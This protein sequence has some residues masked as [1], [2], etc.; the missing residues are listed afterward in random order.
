[1]G[2]VS[3]RDSSYWIDPA[4]LP[5]FAAAGTDAHRVY[6]GGDAWIERFGA[7]LLLSYKGPRARDAALGELPA[8]ARGAPLAY[9]RVFGKFIPVKNE[10]R[11]APELIEGDASLPPTT[12]VRE[13]GMR[14]GIDFAA[15]YSAG[16]F[17]DQRANR[18]FVRR[19]APK[20]LLNTFAYTCSFTVAAALAGAA[21]TSIDLSKRSLDRGRENLALNDVDAPPGTHRFYHDDVLD[22]LPRLARRGETFDAI[23]LDPPTFS[24]GNKGR[25]W[26]VERDLGKLLVAALSVAAPGAKVLVSTNCAR[27]DRRGVESAARD[28]L[29]R[30]GR[31]AAFHQEPPLPDVPAGAAARTL[32]LL[33]KG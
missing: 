15:G 6:T 25:P 9:R 23:A 28:A 29:D 7:D 17:I 11:V 33:L 1:M 4:L 3:R 21:T 8:W 31:S 2:G 27:L 32:W 16:L 14:F 30:A 22:V 12:I 10:E 13:N 5:A 26:Q 24:R 20:R 18:A 19:A